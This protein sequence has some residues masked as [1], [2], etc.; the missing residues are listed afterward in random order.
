M[1]FQATNK[2]KKP[3][4]SVKKIV[5]ANHAVVFALDAL[6]GSFILNLDTGE[7]NQTREADGN[8]MLDVWVPPANELQGFGGPP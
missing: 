3:L 1:K 4:A 8:Y 6:G 2:V 7:V 5:E